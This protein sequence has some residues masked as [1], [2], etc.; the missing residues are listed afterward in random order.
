[1]RRNLDAKYS[2]QQNCVYLFLL[3]IDECI[4]IAMARSKEEKRRKN[5]NEGNGAIYSIMEIKY[6]LLKIYSIEMNN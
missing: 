2:T 3:T 1:M 5:E 4:Y 6:K